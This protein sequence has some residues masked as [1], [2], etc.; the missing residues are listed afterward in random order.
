MIEPITNCVFRAIKTSIK[1]SY[2]TF[3]ANLLA[4][5]TVVAAVLEAGAI[6]AKLGLIAGLILVGGTTSVLSIVSSA[7][8][9][10]V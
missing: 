3:E 7:A 4:E 10:G 9:T 1:P 8:T 5:G 2:S 6:A